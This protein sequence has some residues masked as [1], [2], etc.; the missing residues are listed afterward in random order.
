MKNY[1]LKATVPSV[2]DLIV[3]SRKLSDLFGGSALLP[4]VIRQTLQKVAEKYKDT[5]IDFL[6]PT[7][8]VINDQKNNNI[9]NVV[10]IKIQATQETVKEIGKDIEESFKT[11]LKE[12]LTEKVFSEIKNIDISEWKT[13]ID[14]QIDT[15]LSIV[16]AGVEI[17]DGNL[18]KAKEEVDK[19]VAYLKS[20]A[21]LNNDYIEGY[22]LIPRE[23]NLFYEESFEEFLNNQKN[24]S[25]QHLVGAAL[26]SICG[27]RT[28]IGATEKDPFGKNFWKEFYKNKL[29]EEK[30]CGFCLAKRI[31]HEQK[32]KSVVDYAIKDYKEVDKLYEIIENYDIQ[33]V[34]KENWEKHKKD[35]YFNENIK[36]KLE[37]LYKDNGEPSRFYGLIM[38]DG[39]GMGQK[40]E[41]AFKD[42]NTVKRFTTNMSKYAKDFSEIVWQN[43]GGVIYAG[44]DDILAISPK[45]KTLDIYKNMVKKPKDFT[46]SAG[47][48]FAHYKVPLN[49][50]LQTLRENEKKAKEMG[51]NGVYVSYI[52]HSLS[53]AGC[54]VKNNDIE[55]FSQLI[56][57][58]RESDFPNTLIYQLETILKPYGQ[59]TKH[60]EQV[61]SLALYLI[62]KKKFSKKEE[63]KRLMFESKI[64]MANEEINIS[65][66]VGTLKVAKF[67]A[68]GRDDNS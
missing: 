15:A 21:I 66:I 20:S 24:F 51:K 44:G 9:T 33:D 5:K 36:K 52:K 4:K 50:V 27:K 12:I 46:I 62:N 63:F 8:E 19:T 13:L 3:Q 61:K 41:E 11:A 16:W 55:D 23:E 14:Y 53:S 64:L 35:T 28:I 7:K 57:I 22:T 60:K 38:A 56:D 31:Y 45:S 17:K 65:D 32:F 68:G 40:V 54:F 30:L 49:F 26:C 39:D 47:I 59:K 67:L 1:L 48:V 34:Y 37:E 6:I 42:E 2:Q 43:K 10:Y 25:Y 18:Q 58:V 29:E